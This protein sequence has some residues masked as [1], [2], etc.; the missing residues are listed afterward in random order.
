MTDPY[1]LK[2]GKV[3]VDWPTSHATFSGELC[4]PYQYGT[5]EKKDGSKNH[6]LY[7]K[8]SQKED[9]SFKSVTQFAKIVVPAKM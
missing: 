4:G 2:E 9:N 1:E 6:G 5:L 3:K 8:F 7:H